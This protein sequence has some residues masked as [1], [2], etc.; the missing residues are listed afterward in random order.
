M[1][2]DANLYFINYLYCRSISLSCLERFKKMGLG[3]DCHDNHP[4]DITN[5][6]N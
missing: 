5:F 2:Y 3:N 4:D 1:R 6:Q